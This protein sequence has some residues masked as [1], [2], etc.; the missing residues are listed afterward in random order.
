M[1]ARGTP[2]E[3]WG[4]RGRGGAGAPDLHSCVPPRP[5]LSLPN[6]TYPDP[7]EDRALPYRKPTWKK[8][9]TCSP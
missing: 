5:D 3:W 4:R 1:Y 7:S 2:P 8:Q 6:P 9:V